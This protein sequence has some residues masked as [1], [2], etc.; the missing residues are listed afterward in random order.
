MAMLW[1][2]MS[3]FRRVMVLLM[4]AM[5]LC[6]CVL[7]VVS[8]TRE[9]IAYSGEFHIR[10]M[11]GEDAV[12]TGE[13]GGQLSRFTVSAGTLTY[14]WGE[15]TYGPYRLRYDDTAR[16]EGWTKGDGIVITRGEEVIFEGG[17]SGDTLWHKDGTAYSS[18]GVVISTGDR[19]YDSEG[20]LVTEEER[21]EPGLSTVVRLL[22]EPELTHRGSIGVYLLVTLLAGLNILLILFPDFFFRWNFRFSVRNYEDMEPSDLTLAMR[23]VSWVVLAA[24][25]LGLYWF[26]LT[27]IV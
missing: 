16:P 22:Q 13:V 1:K 6:F 5:I 24:M 26:N 11:G 2:E 15:Y 14:R 17:R 25:T 9:G 23:P 21:R 27:M 20:R 7:T 4:A 18:S 12:Y 3:L 8:V 10:T 19:H